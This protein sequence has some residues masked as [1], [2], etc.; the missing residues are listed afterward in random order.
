[1]KVKK[2]IYAYLIFAVAL[3]A[4]CGARS[5]ETTPEMVQDMLKLRGFKFTEAEF[6]RAINLEDAAS[7]KAF[8]Q[9]GMNPNAKNE[10]GE[11][12]LTYAIQNKDPK[13]ALTL[14]EKADPNMQDALGNSP[15]HLAV[16]NEKDEIFDAL[17]EKNADVNVGGMSG[18]TKNQTALYVAVL[19]DR[20]DLVQR[21]LDKGANP[22]IADSQGAFP[23]SE[24]AAKA[25]A[26]PNVVKRLLDAGANV[27]AQEA[28]KGTA[29]IYA[30]SNK[31]IAPQT[32][33]EIVKL[34]LAK[35]ADKSLKDDKGKTALDWAKESK[36]ADVVDILK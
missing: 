17:L 5:D 20:E 21:L 1:M 34:L 19:K 23:L 9:G 35:G 32:R 11:T 7:V 30:A 6:F 33:T 12:A 25:G 18:K 16:K 29:L 31:S 27:N 28:N 8:L 14:L 26:N 13:I 36:S 24:A 3:T 2:I 4:A 15:I 10:K 22:N